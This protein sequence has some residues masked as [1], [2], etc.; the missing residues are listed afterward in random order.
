MAIE[1]LTTKWQSLVARYQLLYC[2]LGLRTLLL[3]YS[4]NEVAFWAI[5]ESVDR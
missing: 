4:P 1:G 3:R 2:C 5:E